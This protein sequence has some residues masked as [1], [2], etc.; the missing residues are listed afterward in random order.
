[1][2]MHKLL[3]VSQRG[4]SWV[5][6]LRVAFIRSHLTITVMLAFICKKSFFHVICTADTHRKTSSFILYVNTWH[7]IVIMD[8]TKKCAKL[9]CNCPAVVF[10]VLRTEINI[11]ITVCYYISLEVKRQKWK[12]KEFVTYRSLLRNIIFIY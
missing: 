3:S 2:A 12:E 4:W 8:A 5:L 11:N 9:A 6:A 1:M 7:F 10:V